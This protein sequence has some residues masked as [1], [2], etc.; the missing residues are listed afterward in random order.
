M[1]PMFSLYKTHPHLLKA[2]AERFS[3]FHLIVV[4]RGC[5]RAAAL[6]GLAR[7]PCSP[8]SPGI[9][10]STAGEAQVYRHTLLRVTQIAYLTARG[11]RSTRSVAMP[12]RQSDFRASEFESMHRTLR[13]IFFPRHHLFELAC[14]VAPSRRAAPRWDFCQALL[15]SDSYD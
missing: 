6:A 1:P 5:G 12:T 3:S 7:T 4:R 11:F 13:L 15:P 9:H 10:P 14:R 2:P 8:A